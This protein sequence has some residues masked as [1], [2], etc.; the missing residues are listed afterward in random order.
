MKLPPG[1]VVDRYTIDAVLGEGGMAVVYKATHIQLGSTHAVKVLKL[2]TAAIQD[3]LLQEGRVQ[4]QLRHLNIV[5]VTDVVDVDG[6]PG[7]VMEFIAG[8]P[9]SDFLRTHR[10]NLDQADELARGIIEGV[11]VAHQAGLIHRDLKPANILLEATGKSLVPKIT[12]FGLAKLLD[13]GSEG[14]LHTRSGM[15]MGTP[16][17]MA[18]EQIESAK[19]V[20]ARADVFSLGAILYELVAGQRPFQGGST[21]S[22]L[23]AVAAGTRRPL[24]ELVPDVPDRVRIAID[25]ALEPDPDQRIANCDALLDMWTGEAGSDGRVG[26]WDPDTV[27]Q[28]GRAHGPI[29]PGSSTDDSET[30]YPTQGAE[31]ASAPSFEAT[32]P[33]DAATPSSPPSSV[34]PPAPS[35]SS[36][37]S[38]TSSTPRSAR[39]VVVMGI[40]GVAGALVMIGMAWVGLQGGNP[41][42]PRAPDSE[43]LVASRP[44]PVVPEAAEPDVDGP[45]VDDTDGEGE[46]D[47]SDLVDENAPPEPVD[48]PVPSVPR[49]APKAAIDGVDAEQEPPPMTPADDP[50]NPRID[51]ISVPAGASVRIDGLPVGTTPLRSYQVPKGRYKVEMT[52]G[53][54]VIEEKIAV[55]GRRDER[56][57]TWGVLDGSWREQKR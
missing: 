35:A 8:A 37:G 33:D 57:F 28:I 11:A 10:L 23:N 44:E 12:D 4:A 24:Q 46:P 41:S 22:V 39:P 18:P 17:Y 14:Q 6:S 45:M 55:G 40:A 26:V 19:D 47:D 16:A 20:D 3:R 50:D 54:S 36:A 53:D 34:P 2:P 38:A 5:S 13:D 52:L 1:T 42:P 27:S 48:K 7:L 25:G 43:D 21:L 56:I 31:E 9:L 32:L 29:Q 51:L 15:S 49:P 30:Y